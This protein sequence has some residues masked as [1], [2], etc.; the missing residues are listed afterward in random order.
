M[1][2]SNNYES[3]KDIIMQDNCI[4]RMSMKEGEKVILKNSSLQNEEKK[5]EIEI[6][7]DD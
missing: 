6:L 2:V 5:T 1:P 7:I 4:Q 3:Q